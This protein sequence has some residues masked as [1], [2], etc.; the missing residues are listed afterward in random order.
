[1]LADNAQVQSGKLYILGGGWNITGPQPSASAL[2][3]IVH[4]DWNEANLDHVLTFDLVKED[5]EPVLVPAPD[6]ATGPLRLQ[7]K[8]QVGRPPGVAPGSDLNVP[9][10][11]NIGP[12]PLSG[13]RYQWRPR[14]D[15]TEYAEDRLAFSIRSTAPA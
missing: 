5:G 10:A 12:L 11:V 7:V 14:I 4:V 13:G 1:M 9:F 8:F 15:G 3:G 2:V 6:G